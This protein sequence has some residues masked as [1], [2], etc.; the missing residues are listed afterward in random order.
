MLHLM[1][2]AEHKKFGEF[3]EKN[4]KLESETGNVKTF[5]I[6]PK[7]VHASRRKKRAVERLELGCETLPRIYVVAL[8]SQFDFFVGRLLRCLYYLRPG[9]LHTSDRSLSFAQLVAL[10]SV[11]AAREFLIE[12]EVEALLRKSHSE[13]F[14]WLERKFGLPLRKGLDSWSACVELTERRNL[15]VHANGAVS[16]QYLAVCD[17]HGVQVERRPEE[18]EDVLRR[19][20]LHREE[21][22]DDVF[23]V[24]R[25]L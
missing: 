7:H 24:A 3:L 8:V 13:Q 18:V 5:A 9:L 16:S 21:G 11:D 20:V 22:A 17:Q 4:A 15:F 19:S 6:G 14:D 2:L 12:K 25:E 23:G 1:R 10:E